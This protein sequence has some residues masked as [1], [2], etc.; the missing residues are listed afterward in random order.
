MPG[1]HAPV[2]L[3]GPCHEALIGKELYDVVQ[4]NP[5][6]GMH[7]HLVCDGDSHGPQ[8]QELNSVRKR[9]FHV[10]HLAMSLDKLACHLHSGRRP[11]R[12][13]HDFTHRIAHSYEVEKNINGDLDNQWGKVGSLDEGPRRGLLDQEFDEELRQPSTAHV[14]H[15]V[16]EKQ[17]LVHPLV[18]VDPK[19]ADAGMAQFQR[20]AGQGSSK[21]STL[22]VHGDKHDPADA[23]HAHR[24]HQSRHATNDHLCKGPEKGEGPGDNVPH[25]KVLLLI[26]Y[27]AGHRV[28]G[29]CQERSAHAC[30][31]SG[32]HRAVHAKPQGPALP[33][34]EDM[35][36]VDLHVHGL[37]VG[38]GLGHGHPA[39]LLLFAW[40]AHAQGCSHAA[41]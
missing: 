33:R 25:H 7:L 30:K 1:K 28:Q 4:Q 22:L 41:E 27:R 9:F 15:R 36:L 16:D 29:V 11:Q 31:D 24:R 18:G 34:C 2:L 26:H 13:D 21:H 37:H 23:C 14:D 20:A 35:G 39:R 19:S 6:V 38:S 32:K 10:E 5:T 8:S 3:L 12:A 40:M 17:V